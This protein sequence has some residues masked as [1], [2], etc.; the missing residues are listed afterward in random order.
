MFGV[1][2]GP[3]E[4][5]KPLEMMTQEEQAEV[6]AKKMIEFMQSCPGKSIM[7]GVTGF[8]L[9]GVLGIFMASLAHDSPTAPGN[10][11]HLPMKQQMKIMVTDAGSRAWSSAKNFGYIGGIYAGVE[12]CIESL[13]AKHDI[14]NGAAAGCV[15]GAGLSIKAGPQ[16][17]FIGCAGF[18]A[19][20]TAIELYMM[21]D[22]AAPPRNDYDD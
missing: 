5:D 4:P 20:S 3:G 12:C 7:S 18:A 1:Y 2:N 11:N 19:F 15:T 21:S 13:R 10:I 8:G 6:G 16:A 17:A 9:G 14:Y 22:A